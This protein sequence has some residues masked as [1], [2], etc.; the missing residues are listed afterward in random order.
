[1]VCPSLSLDPL[2]QLTEIESWTFQVF[3]NIPFTLPIDIGMLTK[4]WRIRMEGLLIGG[5]SSSIK[6]LDK[7][8]YLE[9]VS[10][11]IGVLD[12]DHKGRLQLLKPFDFPEEIGQLAS[13]KRLEILGTRILRF[14]KSFAGC[15]LL[16]TVDIRVSEMAVPW[17][18]LSTAKSLVELTLSAV[19]LPNIPDEVAELQSLEEINLSENHIR[20]IPSFIKSI[21]N[22][23]SLDLSFNELKTKNGVLRVLKLHARD[24]TFNGLTGKFFDYVLEKSP[25]KRNSNQPLLEFRATGNSFYGSINQTIINALSSIANI[26]MELFVNCLTLDSDLNI[27]KSIGLNSQRSRPECID[28]ITDLRMQNVLR[29]FSNSTRAVI[30]TP[31]SLPTLPT[32]NTIFNP[33]AFSVTKVT[34]TEAFSRT[35]IIPR[36][37]QSNQPFFRNNP[38]LTIITDPVTSP[39]T[40]GRV[41]DANS[42]KAEDVG[43][44]V[45]AKGTFAGIVAMVALVSVLASFT[46]VMLL[47]RKRMPKQDAADSMAEESN[48]GRLSARSSRSLQISTDGLDAT[49]AAEGR[50][51]FTPV[52]AQPTMANDTVK[53]PGV[54][55]SR[56]NISQDG[57]FEALQLSDLRIQD[58]VNQKQPVT[59]EG[60]FESLH[61]STA[62]S[63]EAQVSGNENDDLEGSVDDKLQTAGDFENGEDGLRLPSIQLSHAPQSVNKAHFPT[64]SEDDSA[65]STN[66]VKP[67]SKSVHLWTSGE[68]YHWLDSVGFRDEV[69]EK[70]QEHNV[71][72]QG[73]LGLTD[74]I[75][76][77]EM[78]IEPLSLRNAIL[79]IRGKSFME[80]RVLSSSFLPK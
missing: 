37:T 11:N 52:T 3:Y 55:N 5:L 73:L 74:R 76:K 15:P 35:Q 33:M 71:D 10:R 43:N 1:M 56:L 32:P 64:S 70:F 80:G 58:T 30:L 40:T 72:G 12:T 54:M 77:E 51:F 27:P 68:V 4:L 41:Q 75:L 36:Q 16:K 31:S 28:R 42:S 65:V 53:T 23:T 14:P 47:T 69:C 67:V 44:V 18:W 7:L 50:A 22:L 48:N 62:R 60:L 6:A 9:V 38:T 63:P 46:V 34:D 8:Q 39:S 78:G 61:Q 26:K 2:S 19:K 29:S 20:T 13:L 79:S 24:V 21:S 59:N 66:N 57:L 45:I 49:R 17:N 25:I